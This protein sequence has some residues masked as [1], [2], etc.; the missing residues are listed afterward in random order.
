MAA[1]R[2][3][4]IFNNTHY[5]LTQTALAFRQL[6]RPSEHT[7]HIQIHSSTG[8]VAKDP[9]AQQCPASDRWHQAGMCVLC[10]GQPVLTGEQ[11]LSNSL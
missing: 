10:E 1:K 11:G 5:L 9:T 2:I 8:T 3:R 6:R 4:H 7:K